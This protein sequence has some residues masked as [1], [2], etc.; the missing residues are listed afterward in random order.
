MTR[1]LSKRGLQ[2]A[3]RG[4]MAA[5]TA[6]YG[7]A[8]TAMLFSPHGP[9]GAAAVTVCVAAV[10][11]SALVATYWSMRWPSTRT[12]IAI[13]VLT[14]AG[15]ISA[16]LAQSSP[17]AGLLGSTGFAVLAGYVAFVHSARLLAVVVSG[18]VATISVCVVRLALAGDIAMA[19]S[20][21]PVVS[22]ALVIVPFAMQI[23]A[24]LL[25]S[26]AHR[27]HTDALTGLLNRHGFHTASHE[28]A[29]RL[30]RM[31]NGRL[32][33]AMVDLDQFKQIND[34]LGHS[35]GD[36][37][38]RDVGAALRATVDDDALVARFGGEEFLIAEVGP[39]SR[40]DLG[41]RVLGAVGGLSQTVTASVGV[42]SASHL[43]REPEALRAVLDRLRATADI[44]MYTAKRS[45]GNAVS[46]ATAGDAAAA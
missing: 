19:L 39:A 36:Q 3:A 38:L 11:F 5:G 43:P 4:L 44:A 18:G 6:A 2:P 9:R 40:S 30:A 35:A 12:S 10:A 23:M 26:D 37:I 1:Y 8:A 14:L 15:L 24:R 16:C 27:S 32:T 29:D 21:I 45:G 34:T 42:H 41:D 31:V 20:V 13:V 17:V 25:G 22:V 33:V 7:M 46:H 28:L